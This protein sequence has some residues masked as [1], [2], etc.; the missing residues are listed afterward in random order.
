MCFCRHWR[1]AHP[2]ELVSTAWVIAAVDG[3]IPAA[4]E[5]CF[6]HARSASLDRMGVSYGMEDPGLT[7]GLGSTSAMVLA[8]LPFLL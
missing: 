5:D 7:H 2:E 6:N 3:A 8:N 1:T 4:T